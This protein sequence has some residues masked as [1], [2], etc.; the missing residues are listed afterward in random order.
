MCC[1]KQRQSH[2]LH[3]RQHFK[4]VLAFLTYL[5]DATPAEARAVLTHRTVYAVPLLNPD[6][7]AFNTERFPA[8]G[9]M[10]RKNARG[11]CSS[12]P[13]VDL[14]RNYGFAF[15]YDDEGSAPNSC[16]ATY[17]GPG[18]FSERETALL[19][20]FIVARPEIRV[21][22]NFHSFGNMLLHPYLPHNLIIQLLPL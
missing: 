19:R 11:N 14:N 6:G 5:A 1:K 21:A 16:A 3:C 13:G 20:D 12:H 10:Q 9:G 4:E 22:L 17:R 2:F 18:P 8:G 7:V 15:A